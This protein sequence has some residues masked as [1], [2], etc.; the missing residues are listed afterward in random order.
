MVVGAPGAG[1]S[2]FC[3]ALKEFLNGLERN[4]I[5]INLDSANYNSNLN[6]YEIGIRDL[7]QIDEV[8]QALHLG[9]NGAILYT[10][11]FL[12]KNI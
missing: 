5:L 3:K 9:P 6:D 1:K 12:L 10:Y 4:S 2:L 7:I 11:D 8:M